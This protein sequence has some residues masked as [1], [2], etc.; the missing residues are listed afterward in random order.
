MSMNKTVIIGLAALGILVAGFFALNA[1][2]YSAKQ[3]DEK[4]VEDPKNGWYLF[5]GEWVHLEN[6]KAEVVSANDESITTSYQYFG[7]VARGDLDGDG[8]EDRVFLVTQQ[9]GGSGTFFFLVGAIKEEGGYRGT[10]AVFIG[11][12]IAPQT[13]EFREGR[14]I[15]NFAERKPGEPFTTQPSM[16]KSLYL[17]YSPDHNDFGEVVQ[18]FEGEHTNTD[19]FA[20]VT[21]KVGEKTSALGVTIQVSELVEDSRCPTDV[22][23]VWAGRVKVHTTITSGLGTAEYVFEDTK[24]LTTEAEEITLVQVAP[25]PR[26]GIT[27]TPADYSFTFEIKKR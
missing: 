17:K 14:V 23:C 1:Y 3:V 25:T 19:T 7:N 15:V 11:D 8:D 26:E 10:H 18:N 6:G 20:R 21:V 9:P 13:T 27:L 2:I 16:G 5:S 4:L 12:R 24:S 22:Q